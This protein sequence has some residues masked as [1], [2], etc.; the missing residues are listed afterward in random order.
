VLSGKAFDVK[1]CPDA[2]NSEESGELVEVKEGLI[3]GVAD[4]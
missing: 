3:K 1:M 4:D 2:A